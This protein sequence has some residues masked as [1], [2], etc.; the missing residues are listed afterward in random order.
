MARSGRSTVR[1]ADAGRSRRAFGAAQG[2]RAVRS[3]EMRPMRAPTTELW[4]FGQ[5][6]SLAR[7]ASLRYVLRAPTW[8]GST[9][10]ATAHHL[11]A[12]DRGDLLDLLE[13][14]QTVASSRGR[15]CP[16]PR[17]A[18]CGGGCRSPANAKPAIRNARAAATA[19]I[20]MCTLK[21]SAEVSATTP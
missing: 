14:D 2:R 17:A 10:A 13:P 9:D 1:L 19:T 4:S 21:P 15:L 16:L 7:I 8:C 3:P 11:V 20:R 12:P 6:R 5:R 18:A